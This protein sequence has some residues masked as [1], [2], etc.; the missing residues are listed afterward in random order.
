MSR[1]MGKDVCWA[2]GAVKLPTRQG[3][4]DGTYL[5]SVVLRTE[6]MP[7]LQLRVDDAN[8]D[9]KLDVLAVNGGSDLLLGKWAA[10]LSF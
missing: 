5:P 7:V 3:K 9:E 4:G 2:P 10:C 8:G 1:V 6:T